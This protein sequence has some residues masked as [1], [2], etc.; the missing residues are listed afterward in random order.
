MNIIWNYWPLFNCTGVHEQHT[1]GHCTTLLEFMYNVHHT[2]EPLLNYCILEHH[3]I[4]YWKSWTSYY[5]IG[6][7]L[8]VLEL[9]IILLATELLNYRS[10][11]HE[12]HTIVFWNSWTAYNWTLHNFA[13]IHE[14]YT[15]CHCTTVL[16]WMNILWNCI[17]HCTMHMLCTTVLEFMIVLLATELLYWNSW[18][19][20]AVVLK[21]FPHN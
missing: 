10:V 19:F 4:V 14:L 16:K 12:H 2:I 11:N 5:S 15:I 13:G 8:T 9:M 20:R 3:T 18:T 21:H 7:C 17:G 6:Q 1:I